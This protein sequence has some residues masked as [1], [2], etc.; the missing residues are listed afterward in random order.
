M[1]T[2]ITVIALILL[3]AATMVSLLLIIKNGTTTE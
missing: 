1:G 3:W 2:T